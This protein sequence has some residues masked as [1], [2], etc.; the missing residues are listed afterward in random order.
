MYI[1]FAAALEQEVF[2]TNAACP[3]NSLSLT[4]QMYTCW[5]FVNTLVVLLKLLQ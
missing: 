4:Q 2:F 5:T 3:Y 1:E